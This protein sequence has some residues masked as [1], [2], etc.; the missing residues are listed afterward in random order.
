MPHQ[1]E[2]TPRAALFVFLRLTPRS[3]VQR[4]RDQRLNAFEGS[5]AISSDAYFGN[6]DG[7]DGDRPG[8]RGRS[9]SSSRGGGGGG[10]GANGE[11]YA[12]T[13]VDAGR[14]IANVAASFLSDLADRYSS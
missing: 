1:S 12:T 10:G 2:Q 4:E 7:D 9:Q 14:K 6:D 5:S 13:V 8:S 3:V 11:D